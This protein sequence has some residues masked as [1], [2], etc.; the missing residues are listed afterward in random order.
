RAA[1][2]TGRSEILPLEPAGHV[3]L[4]R[5]R[6]HGIVDYSED[7]SSKDLVAAAAEGYDSV[8]L[9]KRYTTA[10]M[11]PP[12]GKLETINTV[13]LLAEATGRSI[14]ETGTTVWRPPHVPITLGALAG[15]IPE[16]VRYSPMQPWHERHGAVPLVAGQWIRPEHY[17]DPVAEVRN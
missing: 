4:F 6:T 5:A 7:V 1:G 10:T 11:G 13:A 2:V 12:Q 17:G 16:P 14:A 3:G 8:E 15:R 9:L